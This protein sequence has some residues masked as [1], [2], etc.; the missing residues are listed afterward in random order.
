MDGIVDNT[1]KKCEMS[2]GRARRKRQLGKTSH[3]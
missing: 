2:F 1:G 3:R